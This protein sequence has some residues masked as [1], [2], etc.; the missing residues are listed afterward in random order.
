M[1]IKILKDTLKNKHKK[2]V[3]RIKKAAIK[4][5]DEYIFVDL[6]S[7]QW[8]NFKIKYQSKKTTNLPEPKIKKKCG[9][10]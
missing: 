9:C 3:E 10:H 7:K 1:I 5:N 4:E 8:K 2:Y 6:N